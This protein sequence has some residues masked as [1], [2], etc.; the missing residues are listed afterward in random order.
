MYIASHGPY[1]M[2]LLSMPRY[3]LPLFPAFIVAALLIRRPMWRLFAV[4]ASFTLLVGYT[5]WFSSGRWVA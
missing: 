4:G 1:G 3:L 2:G 5:I